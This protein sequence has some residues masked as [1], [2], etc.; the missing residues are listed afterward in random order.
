MV[1]PR[2]V[3]PYLRVVV[4]SAWTKLSKTAAWRS[5]G[6]PMPV[7]RTEKRSETEPDACAVGWTAM[8]ISPDSVNLMALPA[9]FTRTWRIRLGS[10]R[11]H[12]GTVGGTRHAKLRPLACAWAASR[13]AT[14]SMVSRTSKSVTSMVTCP[15]P[16]FEKSR[17][18][19][20]MLSRESALL[21]MVRACERCSA[22]SVV[23]SS[24]LV[25]PITPFIGVRISWLTLAR[26]SDLC[27]FA[28]S[29]SR[30]ASS[31]AACAALRSAVCCSSREFL[32]I[33][34]QND[35]LW[36]F[37]SRTKKPTK[38]KASAP[39]P[40]PCSTPGRS[41]ATSGGPAA[42][43]RKRRKIV[44]LGTSEAMALAQIPIV[45]SQTMI[46]ST[47][48]CSRRTTEAAKHPQ[49]RA[50]R[51]VLKVKARLHRAGAR[52]YWRANT[53]PSWNLPPPVRAAA[54]VKPSTSVGWVP[55]SPVVAPV[56]RQRG[57]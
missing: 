37:P 14:S 15:A 8:T 35:W 32:L 3:P 22:L 4:P 6:M 47:C 13:S 42:H 54:A 56:I 40:G 44:G 2:P 31:A 19:L 24:R 50:C 51:S 12:A 20:M 7:S 41:V 9:R 49:S 11:S 43:A 25:M 34:P 30:R 45:G 28:S 53:R 52:S 36:R 46:P 48:V 26:N 27:R 57:A 1:S 5:G 16:S 38:I 39:R 29:A 18:S 33:A 21:R 17:I 10:P 55:S 23:S